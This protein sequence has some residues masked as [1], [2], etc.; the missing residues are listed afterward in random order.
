MLIGYMRVSS[1]NEG[2][3]TDLQR[4]ALLTAGVDARHLFTDRAS[5]AQD[6]RPGLVKALNFVQPVT[7]WSSGNLT[8]S[9]ARSRTC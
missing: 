1:D 9:A 8:D 6:D 7:C 3:S 2:Q 4:V 5:G